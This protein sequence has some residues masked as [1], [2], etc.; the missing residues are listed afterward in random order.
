[1]RRRSDRGAAAVEFALVSVFLLP[2]L[3]GII[4]YGL[5]FADSLTIRDGARAAARQGALGEFPA[6]CTP[7]RL[8]SADA[9]ELQ[10]LACL[11]ADQARP[12]SGELWV[13]IRLLDQAGNETQ[14]FARGGALRVCLVERHAGL[15]PLVPIPNDGVQVAKVQ[16]AIEDA[17]AI[18]TGG[19]GADSDA[20]TDWAWC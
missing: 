4:D 6:D 8:D 13:K 3:F 18:G 7:A 9:A 15:L 20:P 2:I 5:F 19:G 17:K 10:R 14:T 16:M 12:M 11:A 1:M